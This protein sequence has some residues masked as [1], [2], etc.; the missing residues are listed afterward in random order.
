MDI[1]EPAFAFMAGITIS[2]MAGSLLELALDRPLT[3]S[4]PY[5]SRRHVVR[6]IAAAVVAGPLMFANDALSARRAGSISLLA[7]SLCGCTAVIWATALGTV[8]VS[9]VAS[10]VRP[11]L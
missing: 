2:G 11:L 1:A 4:E 10:S 8:V 9:L 3:F 7:L 5:V 6:S